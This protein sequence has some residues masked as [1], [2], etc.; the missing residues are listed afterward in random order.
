MSLTYDEFG[1]KIRPFVIEA[2]SAKNFEEARNVAIKM[3]QC[4]LENKES[5]LQFHKTGL[6]SIVRQ[7]LESYQAKQSLVVNG[8]CYATYFL[9]KLYENNSDEYMELDL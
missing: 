3:H 7:R 4:I 5:F 6:Y 2:K 9:N 8:F 1:E